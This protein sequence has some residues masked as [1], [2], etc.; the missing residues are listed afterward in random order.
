MGCVG[1]LLLSFSLNLQDHRVA[2]VALPTVTLPDVCFFHAATGWDCPFCGLT[3]SWV[4]LSHGQWK[5]SLAY[6]RLGWIAWLILLAQ[7]PYRI[8]VLLAPGILQLPPR[9]PMR[10][11]VL[12]AAAVL[13]FVNWI[14]DWFW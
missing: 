8:A 11:W 4:A 12:R 13:L 5:A 14:A 7:I 1:V 2:F 6:H 10:D 3:R 9:W